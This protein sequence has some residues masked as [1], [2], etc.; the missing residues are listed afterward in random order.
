MFC[1]SKLPAKEINKLSR[2]I[3][4]MPTVLELLQVPTYFKMDGV[5]LLPTI[6]SNAEVVKDIFVESNP[7]FSD[8]KGLRTNNWF[9][10]F[11]DNQEERLHKVNEDPLLKNNLIEQNKEEALKAKIRVKKHFNI[12]Y[13]E[14]EIDEYTNR[15][16]KKLGYV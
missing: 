14:Q 8:I 12:K 3:D 7:G 13:K 9:Y 15:M 16:L 11:K 1:S 10:I 6:F 5:S 2:T 4:V